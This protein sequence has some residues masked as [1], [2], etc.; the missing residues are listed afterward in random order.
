MATLKPAIASGLFPKIIDIEEDKP[1]L[2]RV[3]PYPSIE[4]RGRSRA[5]FEAEAFDDEIDDAD[6]AA[7]AAG[8]DEFEDIDDVVEEQ[9]TLAG[10]GKP[11]KAATHNGARSNDMDAPLTDFVP[12]RLPLSLI[13]I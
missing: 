2:S 13:H 11:R 9:P 3:S 7:V 6:L 5:Q 1:V 10:S 8:D 12:K 4:P